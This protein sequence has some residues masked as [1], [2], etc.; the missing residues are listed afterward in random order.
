M[1][2]IVDA[3][4]LFALLV[5]GH[6]AHDAARDWWSVQPDDGV[7]SCTPTA[8]TVL[9]LL[10]SSSAMHGYPVSARRALDAWNCFSND[11]R[12]F[13]ISGPAIQELPHLASMV[14]SRSR[15]ATSWDRAW[16]SCVAISLDLELVT[17]DPVYKSFRRLQTRTLRTTEASEK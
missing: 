5:E 8:L 6:T 17:F 16:L 15:G 9:R 14:G 13:H 7:G 1:T 10:T 3:T 4:V 2:C 11:P 12:S